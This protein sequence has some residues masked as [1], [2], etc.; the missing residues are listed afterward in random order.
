M[1]VFN[2]Q[3]K[4]STQTPLM[5]YTNLGCEHCP[6]LMKRSVCI[7]NAAW[8]QVPR[9]SEAAKMTHHALRLS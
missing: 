1:Q 3:E 5:Q 8:T 4:G 2:M 9:F 7:I 6:L